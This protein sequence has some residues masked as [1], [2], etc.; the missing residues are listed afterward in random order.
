MGLT[1]CCIGGAVLDD[2][3]ATLISLF[4]YKVSTLV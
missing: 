1:F 3:A 2:D 4:N